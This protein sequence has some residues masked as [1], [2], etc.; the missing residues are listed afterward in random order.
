MHAFRPGGPAPAMRDVMLAFKTRWDE[1]CAPVPGRFAA[2]SGSA[3]ACA[4]RDGKVI[5]RCSWRTL[6][7]TQRPTDGP[8]PVLRP[9]SKVQTPKTNLRSYARNH[10]RIARASFSVA[11]WRRRRSM[12]C[13]RITTSRYSWPTDVRRV[14]ERCS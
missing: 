4:A 11:D 14:P 7:R 5:H 10:E 6:L 3:S 2:V 9:A 12:R 8:K 1:R 13:I